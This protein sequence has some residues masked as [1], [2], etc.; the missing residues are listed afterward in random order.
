MPALY[1]VVTPL[2]GVK[3]DIDAVSGYR[4]MIAAAVMMLL[5]RLREWQIAGSAG[6][7][8]VDA[9]ARRHAR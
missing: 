5:L 1:Y 4:Q 3:I 8:Y 6:A 2:T 9:V 7:L